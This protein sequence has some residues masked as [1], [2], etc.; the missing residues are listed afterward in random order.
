[1]PP[2]R[3]RSLVISGSHLYYITTNTETSQMVA[4]VYEQV[5][6]QLVRVA[7]AYNI[8]VGGSQ[9]ARVV[10]D[11][12]GLG[13]LFG[14]ANT[15]TQWAVYLFDPETFGERLA[16]N[17]LDSTENQPWSNQ[18]EAAN[19]G[20]SVVVT[21]NSNT[22]SGIWIGTYDGS[23]LLS[24]ASKNISVSTRKLAISPM[25][26][27]GQK[28]RYAQVEHASGSPYNV[29]LASYEYDFDTDTFTRIE[30]GQSARAT[31]A[32]TASRAWGLSLRGTDPLTYHAFHT[33]TPSTDTQVM[34]Y[35]A[36][37][38]GAGTLLADMELDRA[39]SWR[40][41][42]RPVDIGTG[43]LYVESQ[44]GVLV[45]HHI[46]PPTV[47]PLS[48]GVPDY[49]GDTLKYA[50]GMWGESEAPATVPPGHYD[51]TTGLLTVYRH[52]AEFGVTAVFEVPITLEEE[53]ETAVADL[54]ATGSLVASGTRTR[55]ADLAAAATATLAAA[56]VRVR[57]GQAQLDATTALA[58][59]GTVLRGADAIL[60]ASTALDASASRTRFAQLD[61][62][63]A[64]QLD[65]TARTTRAV[66][67]D[68]QATATLAGTTSGVRL[69]TALLDATASLTAQGIRTSVAEAAL[70][71]TA[72]LA[73]TAS[74]ER[75]AA[76]T[77]AATADL[78]GSAE[79]T[80]RLAATID[81]TAQLAATAQR[82]A[83]A[84][85]TLSAQASLSA[86]ADVLGVVLASADL[87]A[88]AA[89]SAWPQTTRAATATL[90][91]TAALIA[92]ATLVAAQRQSPTRT[93]INTGWVNEAGGDENLHLSVAGEEPNYDTWAQSAQPPGDE[94]FGTGFD[95]TAPVS[96]AGHVITVV[97]GKYPAEDGRAVH[98][99]LQLVERGTTVATW[100]WQDLPLV[101]QEDF[102]L[103][104]AQADEIVDY[105]DVELRFTATDSGGGSTRGARVY[106]V[107]FELPPAITYTH[108][109]VVATATL[110]AT[111][112]AIRHAVT[113][114]DA[115]AQLAA[116]ATVEGVQFASAALAAVADVD[117]AARVVRA[118]TAALPAT[119][120]LAATASVGAA[121]FAAAGLAATADVDAVATRARPAAA[122]LG[123]TAGLSATASLGAEHLAT[124][125][126]AA[127][128]GMAAEAHVERRAFA[129]LDASASV[130]AI[131]ARVRTAL[132]PL[133]ATTQLA[134]LA[135]TAKP[136]GT[137]LIATAALA[138][139]ATRVRPVA[140]DLPATT[141]LVAAA[142]PLAWAQGELY[143]IAALDAVPTRLIRVD[144]ALH[145]TATLFA[146]VEPSTY[147][148]ADLWA[149]ASMLVS[150]VRI[151]GRWA[152]RKP[153]AQHYNPHDPSALHRRKGGPK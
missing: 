9:A 146:E 2:H 128:A 90:P 1:M 121:V 101:A 119:A 120:A 30:A 77:M 136:A 70:A 6:G 111:A 42:S 76:S 113:T 51:E 100:D 40:D 22:V 95:L 140:A 52:E 10:H 144:A 36:W 62:L 44:G 99:N 60:A 21:R 138:A 118:A 64:A 25:V 37:E 73:V 54:L 50:L 134:A 117:A 67:A 130:S 65:A 127:T 59:S 116:E 109:V 47:T 48:G 124:A 32:S 98:L 84:V 14:A 81:V 15:A 24:G 92:D 137:D 46:Q 23:G 19:V 5:G 83:H 143:A 11:L 133:A 8:T 85:A 87:S 112:G 68:L 28:V 102:V 131:G 88:T 103:T 4:G 123:A 97:A 78:A 34:K 61:A 55:T 91:A 122:D 29:V 107:E 105:G 7:D 74:P 149:T 17:F 33:T 132:A 35:V 129:A 31:L 125:A 69:A 110:D 153:K 56:T 13:V 80:R 114:L 66:A 38:W 18:G 45:P 148:E 93:T 89:L 152:P 20:Q 3:R 115:T 57:V 72:A 16:Y 49:D 12:P 151:P 106:W 104:E 26:V 27:V 41:H 135:R 75:L 82:A 58:A 53:A 108:L 142:T 145:A 126:L 96:R 43:F 94:K 71:A 141:G 150:G 63:A 79:R 39:T 147:V 86:S 139:A